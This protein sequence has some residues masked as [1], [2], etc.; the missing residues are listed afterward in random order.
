MLLIYCTSLVHLALYMLLIYCT[1]LVHIAHIISQVQTYSWNFSPQS[2]CNFRLQEQQSYHP[3]KLQDF[4]KFWLV[5]MFDALVTKSCMNMQAFYF[6]LMSYPK[7]M[8]FII[9]SNANNM[10]CDSVAMVT[11]N[12]AWKVCHPYLSLG[13]VLSP[14]L[15]LPSCPQANTHEHLQ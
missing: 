4:L 5:H 10:G 15:S 14:M 8:K 6:Q 9:P 13:L 1:S 3:I 12:L 2:S 7:E 11:T